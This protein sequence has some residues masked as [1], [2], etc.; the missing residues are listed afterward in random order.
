MFDWY[1]PLGTFSTFW[2]QGVAATVEQA[3]DEECRGLPEVTQPRSLASE[4]PN[5]LLRLRSALC[6][7]D[8]QNC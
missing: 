4:F 8:M 3:C 5:L 1:R 6:D 7:C 2:Q